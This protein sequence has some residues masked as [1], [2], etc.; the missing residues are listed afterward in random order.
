F[1]GAAA[2]DYY[3]RIEAKRV[4]GDIL[5]SGNT[6][7]HNY[8]TI[9]LGATSYFNYDILDVFGGSF[10]RAKGAGKERDQIFA[11]GLL[12]EGTFRITLKLINSVTQIEA[13]SK[14]IDITVI[15]PYL[16]PVYPVDTSVTKAALNF[17][18]LTNM[19]NKELHIFTD[20]RGN[21]EILAGNR[22]PIR[23]VSRS[24]RGSGLGS[25]LTD[26]TSY[27]WQI[28]GHISTT[29]GDELV[30]GPLS[31]F[32]YFEDASYVID[33]GLSDKDKEQIMDELI[34]ILEEL[35]NKRAAKSISTYDIDR[36]VLDNSVVTREEIMAILLAIKSKQLNVNSVYFK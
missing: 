28:Y 24:Y 9:F 34:I 32:L 30:K 11:T 15:P 1:G 27:Y 12:P 29:H 22:L 10:S 18:W 6:D 16:Q 14:F 19:T 36:I 25:L 13:D 20:P 3:L 31:A 5:L 23:N 26:A 21:N 33:L 7:S 8:N 2:G 4:G 35:I 17:K